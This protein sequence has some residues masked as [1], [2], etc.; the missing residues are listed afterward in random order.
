M[1]RLV[2]HA[3]TVFSICLKYVIK[4]FILLADLGFYNMVER[5]AEYSLG[6]LM[7]GPIRDK[8]GIIPANVTWGG[9]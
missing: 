6:D 9:T 8:L 4:I 5:L 2:F 3:V 1:T 7:N